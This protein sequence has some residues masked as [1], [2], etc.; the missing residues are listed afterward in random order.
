MADRRQYGV[1]PQSIE[2]A[3]SD[4]DRLD[5][6]VEAIEAGSGL[7]SVARAASA[8]LESSIA[9]IDRSG[10]VLAIAAGSSAEERR[11][12]SIGAE[13]AV[14]ELRVAGS[15]V[16]ELRSRPSGV[17]P[18]PAVERLVTVLLALELER[19]RAPEWAADDV[20]SG[21][22][23]A[24]LAREVTDRG[25]ISAR[26]AEAG[27]D[28]GGGASVVIARVSPRSPQTG[29]WRARVLALTLR[30][31]RGVSRTA[32]ATHRDT[33]G[34]G[35]EVAAIVPAAGP[36]VPE[37]AAAALKRELES[38]LP[39]FAIS[40]GLGQRVVDPVDLHR[41]GS[42]AL[43]AVN[44]GEATGVHVLA[45][46]D[47]GA[48]RLLLPASSEDAVELKRFYAETIAPLVEYDE[49]YS[50]ELLGT[51]EAY[52]ESD[53]AMVATAERL[54]THRHTVRYRLDRVRELT[55]HSLGSSEGR[56]RLSL[57]L[58]AMRVLGIA[59]PRA[60]VREPGGSGSKR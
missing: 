20:A 14:S 28:L 5:A 12:L 53:G 8:M 3:G 9:L 15:I 59:A 34:E 52:L 60:P 27:A 22:V 56:E 47:S 18:Q 48:Y 7:P 42:E 2:E 57:G 25:D 1:A 31:L 36:E 45:Y 40:I 17:A 32:M 6:L 43:L 16:G 38:G 51:V 29:D 13:V 35:A 21:F 54:F 19:S 37:R 41:S 55:G 30:G 4:P 10:A 58:K 33:D 46:E 24:V 11:L 23:D 50:T 44:V 49:Q 26:A 39:G